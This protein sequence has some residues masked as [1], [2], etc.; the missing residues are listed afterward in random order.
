MNVSHVYIYKETNAN[1]TA[2]N[3]SAVSIVNLILWV[4]ISCLACITNQKYK[5]VIRSKIPIAT[6]PNNLLK[7]E[8]PPHEATP[9]KKMGRLRR[10][11]VTILPQTIL[12]LLTNHTIVS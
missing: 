1:P 10:Y 12:N 4:L 3:T 2:G 5:H 6:A 7:L 9:T 11:R 8:L